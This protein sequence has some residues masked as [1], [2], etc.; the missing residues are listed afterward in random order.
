M[1]IFQKGTMNLNEPTVPLTAVEYLL[2]YRAAVVLPERLETAS[3]YAKTIMKHQDRY[4]A[5]ENQTGCPWWVIGAIHQREASG[6]FNTYLQNGDPLFDHAG[7]AIKTKN[8]PHVGPFEPQT[9]EVAAVNAIGSGHT[10]TNIGFWLEFCERYN[11]LGYRN[12]GIMSPYL[13]SFTDQYTGGLFVSDGK[14]DPA[15]TDGQPGCAAIM[16]LLNI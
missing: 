5:I 2:Q 12:R 3:S 7:V 10:E 8:L 1:G 13:W 14:F 9:W 4:Q 6:D 15:A 16:K 11:G